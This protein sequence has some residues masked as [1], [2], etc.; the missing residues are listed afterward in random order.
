[1]SVE[2]NPAEWQEVKGQ[3]SKKEKIIDKL[4]KYTYITSLVRDSPLS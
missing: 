2:Q 4:I 1:M 3:Y